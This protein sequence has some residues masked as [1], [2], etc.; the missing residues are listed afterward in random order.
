MRSSGWLAALIQGIERLY[1]K[2]LA[3]TS[4]D[5]VGLLLESPVIKSGRKRVLLAIDLTTSVADE[6]LGMYP[7]VGAI[8]VYHPAIFK[9]IKSLTLSDPRHKILLRLATSGISVY[10][11][12]T[13]MDAAVGGINDWLADGISDN[14]CIEKTVILP[15]KYTDGE[16]VSNN[17]PGMGRI[18]RW[19]DPI[20][21]TTLVE[22]IKKLLHLNH[23]QLALS[24][25]H[26]KEGGKQIYK[27]GICA[28]SGSGTILRNVHAD[29]LFTG[30]LSHHDILSATE[31]G[32]SVILCGHSNTERG[33]LSCVM[34][35]RLQD[36]LYEEFRDIQDDKIL[37]PEVVVS[38][39]DKD[40]LEIV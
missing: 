18:V 6:A 37:L 23:V 27:I 28:G 2:S 11:P 5:N 21:I 33:F 15:S 7:P 13:A 40:P 14:K 4:W 12:H 17:I 34:K 8:I 31:K 32:I 26:R 10:S 1:P 30:E 39:A 25:K 3:D 35:K 36:V 19:E 29:V 22:R 24:E 20:S 38:E 16:S 9:P